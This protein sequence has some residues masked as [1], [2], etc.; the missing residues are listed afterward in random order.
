[1]NCTQSWYNPDCSLQTFFFKVLR[2]KEFRPL[3]VLILGSIS[4]CILNWSVRRHL[5]LIGNAREA[6][7]I[8]TKAQKASWCS[9]ARLINIL[10][11]SHTN[12]SHTHTHRPLHVQLS[13]PFE[14]E[15]PHK[16]ESPI[17]GNAPA[18]RI[19]VSTRLHRE[20]TCVHSLRIVCSS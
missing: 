6:A 1:M 10:E 20:P 3:S 13:G 2:I 15:H 14:M 16:P 11:R 5:C 17:K 7:H 18:N 12:N 4:R 8:I 19:S 9:F